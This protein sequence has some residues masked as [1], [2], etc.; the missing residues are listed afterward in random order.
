MS[1][2]RLRVW[3]LPTRIFHIAL[4]LSV[5]TAWFSQEFW[6]ESMQWHHWN[7]L[8]L[9]SILLTRIGWGFVGSTTARFSHFVPTPKRLWR[10][11]KGD[12]SAAPEVG[13]N[14]LGALSVLLILVLLLLMTVS[15]LFADD[16]FIFS[17]PLR[18]LLDYDLALTVTDWHRTGYTAVLGLILLH[19]GAILWYTLRGKGLVLPMISGEAL[20]PHA[21][22]PEPPLHFVSSWWA[23]LLWLLF[24]LPIFWFLG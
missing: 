2:Q 19:L 1:Y 11:L 10:Y 16:D 23:L 13:H 5:T 8:F 17:G 20:L 7:G 21:L 14:P 24:A 18:Y 9:L 22:T 15:G 6:G 4:I 3:D 12:H